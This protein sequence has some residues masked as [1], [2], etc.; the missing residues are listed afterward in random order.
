VFALS[1]LARWPV[2]GLLPPGEDKALNARYLAALRAGEALPA[3]DPMMIAPAGRVV[4]EHFPL[5][6]Y[7]VMEAWTALAPAS[8]ADRDRLRFGALQALLFVAALLWL[9][10][11]AG[12]STRAAVWAGGL[13]LA[14]PSLTLRTSAAWLRWE[15]LGV[16]ALLV[17]GAASARALRLGSR[18]AA[19]LAALALPLAAWLWRPSVTLAAVALGYGLLRLARGRLDPTVAR[20]LAATALGT[21]AACLLPAWARHHGLLAGPIGVAA[22]ATFFGVIAWRAPAVAARPHAGLALAA[23]AGLAAAIVAVAVGTG[24]YSDLGPLLADRVRGLLGSA[25]RDAVGRLYASV[26]EFHPATA[27]FAKQPLHELARDQFGLLVVATGIVAALA[28]R[29]GGETRAPSGLREARGLIGWVALAYGVLTLLFERSL[30]VAAP[31]VAAWAGSGVALAARA[32]APLRGVALAL[33]VAAGLRGLAV[34]P[35]WRAQV[36]QPGPIL[37]AGIAAA[38]AKTTPATAVV[39]AHWPIGYELPLFAGRASWSDGLLED[40]ENRRRILE[41]WAPGSFEPPETWADQLRRAGATHVLI[42]PRADVAVSLT[43]VGFAQAPGIDVQDGGSFRVIPDAPG[44]GA[45]V[46]MAGGRDV[47]GFERMWSQQAG[48]GT[49]WSLYAIA[50]WPAAAPSVPSP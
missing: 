50:P 44:A 26:A 6:L 34:L 46:Q 30:V 17:Y 10:F 22:L 15:V 20:W 48:D 24:P 38:V 25:D 37:P 9:G 39:A 32:R 3:H 23:G 40:A 45:M 27:R 16:A 12:G 47:A 29:R 1:L 42:G 5:G 19:A 14:I 36:G 4:A 18:G 49:R 21:A 13:A 11:E 2:H 8:D 35:A 28:V 33:A 31:F 7:R 43:Y 41:V